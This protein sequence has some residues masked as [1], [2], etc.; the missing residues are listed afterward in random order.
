MIHKGT[1]KIPVSGKVDLGF[2]RS[3]SCTL[4]EPAGNG[5]YRVAGDAVMVSDIPYSADYDDEATVDVEIEDHPFDRGV[6]KCCS[7]VDELSSEVSSLTASVNVG[8]TGIA[9]A[10]AIAA[11]T[12]GKSL[13]RGFAKYIGY[14]IKEKMTLLKAK[15]PGLALTLEAGGK[16]LADRKGGLENDYLIECHD[17]FSC[18][19]YG[20][21]D[22]NAIPL[23]LWRTWLKVQREISK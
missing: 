18:G 13:S 6:A 19:L 8:A 9:G 17:F 5:Q 12:I 20:F 10:K 4:Y 7:R 2:I 15:L 23:M 1:Y 22:N 3:R 11:R 21:N 16:Q 14:M